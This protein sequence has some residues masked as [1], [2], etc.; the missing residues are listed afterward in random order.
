MIPTTKGDRKFQQET[1]GGKENS[2]QEIWSFVRGILTGAHTPG[3]GTLFA[4]G[5]PLGKWNPGIFMCGPV[6]HRANECK[7]LIQHASSVGG[8]DTLLMSVRIQP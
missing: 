3:K 5:L 8:H 4:R 7:A 2:L 1:I 6:G